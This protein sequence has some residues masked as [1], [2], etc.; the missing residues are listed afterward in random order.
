MNPDTLL[1][2]IGVGLN[3]LATLGGGIAYMIRVEHRFTVL[4]TKMDERK[5]RR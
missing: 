3:T 5:K 1:I 4:E 2:L